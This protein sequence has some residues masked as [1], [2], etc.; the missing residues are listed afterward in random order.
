MDILLSALEQSLVLLP[1]VLGI[2]LSYRIL[3]VTDLTVDGTYVLGAAIFARTID[4]GLLPA[5]LLAIGGGGAIGAIVAFM[6]RRDLVSSLV[7][8]ILASFMLY[9]VNLQ[10]MGRPNISVLGMP[11]LLTFSN[12]ENW[13]VPLSIIAILLLAGLIMLL[14]S[15]LGLKLRAF[16]HN[17]RLL[18]ALGKKA[19]NYRLFGLMLSNSLAA[20]SGALATQVN[21]FADINMGLGVALVS[22]GAVVIGGHI[23][24]RE[25]ENFKAPKEVIS[26]FVGILLYFI[27][28]SGLLRAGINPANLKLALGLVLFLS[29]R[30][31]C[32]TRVSAGMTRVY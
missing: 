12:Q 13:I 29:L 30:S 1:L 18:L 10:F 5:C 6:Q 20:L 3:N 26:C 17:Q 11:S 8:G 15:E 14:S 27:C 25:H 24:T 23:F 19:E 31:T 7:V 9:S 21:G 22:I 28:L 2:Y 16:G 4:F 32:H